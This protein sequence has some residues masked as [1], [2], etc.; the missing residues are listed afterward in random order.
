MARPEPLISVVTASFNALEGL[1]T[2]VAS[3]A[4]QKFASLEHVIIDGGSRDGTVEYLASLGTS[5]SWV[6]EPDKGIADALNKGVAKAR[7]QYIII[8]Q[9]E[10]YFVSEDI[11]QSLEEV[12]DSGPD[13]VSGG[14]LVKEAEGGL[15]LVRSRGLGW[16]SLIHMTTP[17]QGMFCRRDLWRRIGQFDDSYKIAMDYEFVL[18]ARQSGASWHHLPDA[19]AVMPDTGV[20][21]RLD[22]E[23]LLARLGEF[24][25][26]QFAYATGWQRPLLSLYWTIYPP[27]KLA[28]SAALR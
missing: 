9:A 10:D 8:L 11:L 16:R 6:S 26:A 18:R 3:V 2:T 17:H 1:K 7:G 19:I 13:I 23:G 24:R 25:R 12:F 21:S 27:V 20:S 4:G 15:R 5:V 14:V 22:R 28:K